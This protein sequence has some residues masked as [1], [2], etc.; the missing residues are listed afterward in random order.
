[1]I[2]GIAT[3]KVVRIGH[4]VLRQAGR[5][6]TP[7][8]V[9]SDEV[10]RLIAEMA[11]S[12]LEYA[13]VGIAANQVGE[14]LALFLMGLEAGSAR[15]PDGIELAVV[16]NPSVR[17]L[18]G[19]METDWEGCLSLPGLRGQVERHRKLELSGLDRKGRPFTR[20]YEGFPA[21]VVQHEADHLMGKVYLDRMKDL[22]S[23]SYV[24][25]MRRG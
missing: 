11:A 19:D 10:Q 4:P 22:S 9:G 12:M 17:F 5:P 25:E 6:L 2:V 14:S 13:G 21:R 3:R 7:K 1:M 24:E 18:G 8:E 23:L 20:V 15:H 16:F